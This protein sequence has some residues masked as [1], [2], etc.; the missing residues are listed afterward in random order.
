MDDLLK[1]PGDVL[2]GNGNLLKHGRFIAVVDYH[3]AIPTQTHFIVNPTGGLHMDYQDHLGGFILLKP[4]DAGKIETV[5]YTLELA[6]KSKK[7]I[8]V[9]RR[10]KEV[11]HKGEPRISFW[12]KG[13]PAS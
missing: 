7:Q 6:D 11:T 13:K 5:G 3:L 2:E 4:D 9:E 8:T 12:I 1:K 10:Y